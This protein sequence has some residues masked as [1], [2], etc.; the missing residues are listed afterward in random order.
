MVQRKK[1]FNWYILNSKII[2]KFKFVVKPITNKYYLNLFSYLLLFLLFILSLQL[3]Y[4]FLNFLNILAIN[5]FDLFIKSKA[6]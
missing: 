5:I 6:I 3:F 2:Y 1:Y 4:I